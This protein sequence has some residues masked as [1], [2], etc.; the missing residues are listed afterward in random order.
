MK[1]KKLLAVVCC[2]LAFCLVA[3][4]E[5]TTVTVRRQPYV[6]SEVSSK[7]EIDHAP[8]KYCG[9]SIRYERTYRRDPY[10]HEWKET[11]EKVPDTCRKCQSKEK[12]Q[13]KLDREERQL[14]QKID[15]LKTKQR[16]DS[17][18]KRLSRLRQSTR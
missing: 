10:T 7:S 8:C 13:E 14:D 6:V 2:S 17:K 18:K 11:T 4:G 5:N 15:Y 12:A 16:I 9:S 3:K 1:T